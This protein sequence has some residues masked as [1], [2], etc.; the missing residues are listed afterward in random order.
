MHTGY[1]Q[2]EGG[3]IK[4]NSNSLWNSKYW[5]SRTIM[6]KSLLN[7]SIFRCYISYI[8]CNSFDSVRD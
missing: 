6:E 2:V 3:F 4:D 5:K 8:V 7:N 1:E